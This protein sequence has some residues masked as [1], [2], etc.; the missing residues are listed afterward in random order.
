M[1]L[2]TLKS[3]KTDRAYAVEDLRG[4]KV[5]FLFEDEDDAN[6]YALQLKDQENIEMD[7]VEV[8]NDLTIKTCR[9]NNYKYTIVTSDDIIIPPKDVNF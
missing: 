9:L 2:L 3:R 1:F 4:N 8:D 6:R 7:V 5:L